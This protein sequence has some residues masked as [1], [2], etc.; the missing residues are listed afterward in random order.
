MNASRHKSCTRHVHVCVCAPENRHVHK[1]APHCPQN[2]FPG[3][4]AGLCHPHLRQRFCGIFG[5]CAGCGIFG[6]CAGKWPPVKLCIEFPPENFWPPVTVTIGLPPLP[7]G[8]WV[9][10]YLAE[11]AT[12]IRMQTTTAMTMP[13]KYRPCDSMCATEN[14]HVHIGAPHVRRISF[15]CHGQ[16]SATHT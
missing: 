12:A 9:L 16:V 13:G 11:R 2:F 5:K 10:Q 7:A 4:L 15:R 1:G 3:S 8:C 14:R 6:K